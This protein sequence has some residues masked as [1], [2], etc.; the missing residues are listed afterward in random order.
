MSR[1]TPVRPDWVRPH[2]ESIRCGVEAFAL[3]RKCPA[4]DWRLLAAVGLRETH[5]G[6]APGYAPEGDSE[7][8][9]DGGHGH[10]FFQIDDR[11]P[12]R[13]LI[14]PFPWPVVAQVIAAC[15]VLHDARVE[16]ARFKDSP[17]FEQ[18]VICAYNA[19]SPRVARLLEQNKNPDLA[20]ADG[21]DEDHQGD[22][23]S[24]VQRVYNELRRLMP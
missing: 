20:T 21:P 5:L 11:G 22:Y 17:R 23:G 9:G 18:A 13:H 3:D 14:R 7:G 15:Q 8:V 2:E 19:G 4:E 24:D 10:G 12:Y 1:G 16:L 6:H